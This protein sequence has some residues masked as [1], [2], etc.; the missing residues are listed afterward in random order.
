MCLN[1]PWSV[2]LTQTPV[3]RP[4]PIACVH[5]HTTL[6]R[7]YLAASGERNPWPARAQLRLPSAGMGTTLFAGI[8]VRD[9]D[10]AAA[11][12]ERFLGRPASFR[13]HETESVWELTGQ[14]WVYVVQRPEHA[15]HGLVTVLVDDLAARVA[16]VAGRGIE[17]AAREEY[18]GGARKAV[19]RDPD[20][21]EF[22]LAEAPPG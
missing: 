12:Y 9:H 21:N 14:A 11:W 2:P 5:R 17:P 7:V 16:E 1:R 3:A 15:G 4:A 10:A 19:Y 8:P 18:G 6:S 22:G 13:A 20:G